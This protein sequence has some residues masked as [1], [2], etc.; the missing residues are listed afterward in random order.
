MSAIPIGFS[1]APIYN[2]GTVPP[3][4]YVGTLAA[5]QA[6]ED[7]GARRVRGVENR[8]SVCNVTETPSWRRHKITSAMVCNACGLYYNLHGRDREF[9]INSRGLKV[10]KRQPRGV[11]KKRRQE[12]ARARSEANRLRI[13]QMQPVANETGAE[14]QDLVQHLAQVNNDTMFNV[15]NNF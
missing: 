14:A 5:T 8:C 2:G 1:A 12:L 11:S 10:V 13:N 3:G 9:V 15:Y 6:I 4:S 7:R